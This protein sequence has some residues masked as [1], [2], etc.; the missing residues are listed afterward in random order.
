[1]QSAREP[2]KNKSKQPNTRPHK[3]TENWNRPLSSKAG[4]PVQLTSKGGTP[5]LKVDLTYYDGKPAV[6]L[7]KLPLEQIRAACGDETLFR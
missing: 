3:L 4:L 5:F 1:M 7:P 2:R 6:A